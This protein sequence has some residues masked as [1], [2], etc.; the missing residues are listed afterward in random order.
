[1][2]GRVQ[3]QL[4]DITG[5]ERAVVLAAAF[6]AARPIG[7]GA[8]EP[9]VGQQLTPAR[10]EQLLAYYGPEL[11]YLLGRRLDLDLT[12]DRVDPAAYDAANAPVHLADLVAALRTPTATVTT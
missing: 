12:S 3:A 1:M 10:A 5:L 8:H 9:A 6:N 4:V 11:H 7:T 2:T